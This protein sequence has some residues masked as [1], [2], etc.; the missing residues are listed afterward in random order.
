MKLNTLFTI[1]AVVSLAYAIGL[2]LLPA[3][4][5][6]MYGVTSG[7][8]EQLMTQLFGVELLA[9]GLVAWFARNVTDS[10]ARR[11]ILLAFLIS[12]VIGVVVTLMGTLSGGFNAVGWSAVAIYLLL[13][14]GSAYFQFMKPSG[15]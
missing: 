9:V 3:T 15:T 5:L 10:S 7:P 4:L 12:Q 13:G 2:L 11:A 1:T 6:T 14:L 8:G